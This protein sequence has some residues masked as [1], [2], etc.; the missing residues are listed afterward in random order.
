MQEKV[1]EVLD[2]IRPALQRD[3]GD[4][5]LVEVKD[6]IVSVRLKGACGGCPMSQMTLKM[7]IEREIKRLVPEV[8]QV[9]AV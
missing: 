7:G 5:E 3:G 1:K 9:I 4:V 8:K 2:K 6:G